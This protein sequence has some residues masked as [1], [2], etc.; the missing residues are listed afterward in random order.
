VLSSGSSDEPLA[1]GYVLIFILGDHGITR[2]RKAAIPLQNPKGTKYKFPKVLLT[3]KLGGNCRI[4]I[5]LYGLC[6]PCLV[7]PMIKARE[8]VYHSVRPNDIF[9]R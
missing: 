3:R 8:R 7:K 6:G 1:K 4:Q 9:G 2:I 5:Q